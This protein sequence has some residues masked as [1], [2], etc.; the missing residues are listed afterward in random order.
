VPVRVV[1]QPAIR[2]GRS[3]VALRGSRVQATYLAP[4]RSGAQTAH[5]QPEGPESGWLPDRWGGH[6]QDMTPPALVRKFLARADNI[7]PARREATAFA[8]RLG[9]VNPEGVALAVSEALT[10]AV[11]HAYVDAAKPGDVEPVAESIPDDGMRVMVC[12][13]GRGM[14]PRPD[15]PG[16]GLGLPLIASIAQRFDVQARSGGGTRLCMYFATAA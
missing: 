16:A 10:N 7:G 13:D 1:P 5:A 6:T 12:D 11:V 9:A 14:T 2:C 8:R 3:C 15:S 4:A